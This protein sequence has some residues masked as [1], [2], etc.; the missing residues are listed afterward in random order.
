VLCDGSVCP[1]PTLGAGLI[2]PVQTTVTIVDKDA[3]QTVQFSAPAYTVSETAGSASITV[4]R[5]GT[6]TGI[7]LVN[8][9]PVPGTMRTLTFAAGVRT[10][11]V[12]VP[13]GNN[14]L[15]DG[16]RTITLTL[17]SMRVDGVPTNG[18][19]CGGLAGASCTV[20]LTVLDDD[21]AGTVQFSAT[22]Y[23][24][25]EAMPVA[26]IILQ[27]SGG[28]AS[29]VTVEMVMDPVSSRL[30]APTPNPVTFG[31]GVFM[32]TVTI[33]ILKPNTVDDGDL[34]V[35]LRLVNPQNGLALGPRD[36][37]KLTIVDDDVP[38]VIQFGQ[39]VYT[40]TEPVAP[41][42]VATITLTRTGGAAS[43]VTVDYATVQDTRPCPPFPRLPG[44]SYACAGTNYTATSGT[45]TFAAGQMSQTFPVT[46]LTDGTPTGTM[47][48]GLVLS[49]PGGGATLGAR[50]TATLN[51][52]DID[53][54]VGF[55]AES[56]SVVEGGSAVVTLE[57]TGAV[58]AA[59]TVQYATA[60][61]GPCPAPAGASYGCAGTDYTA[62][63]GTLTFNPGVRTLSFS[64]PTFGNV[65]HEGN[66]TFNVTLTPGVLGATTLVRSSAVVTIVDNDV[67]GAIAFTSSSFTAPSEFG[68]VNLSVRRPSSAAA[69]PVTVA[70]ST[71]DG[72][73]LAGRDYVALSGTLTFPPG[74]SD[75]MITVTILGNSRDDGNRTFQV[76]LSSPTGGAT[77]G[78]QS[79]ANVQINDDDVAGFVQFS[80]VSFSAPTTCTVAP[81]KAALTVKRF[82]GL[83]SG[84]RVDYATV[85]GTGNA[86]LD[87]VPVTDT[88]A[89]GTGESLKTVLIEL[90]PSATRGRTFGVLLSQPRGGAVLG[91]QTTATVT[92]R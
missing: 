56:Y 68:L 25:L 86:L 60:N 75:R 28:A 31:A 82:G 77:L 76:A 26:T 57:R 42:T 90:R 70:F 23:R 55:A 71:V 32:Q 73:A 21:V 22:S 66:R 35:V 19:T 49:D 14:T 20:P 79:T 5:L 40:I 3:D 17:D 38:G 4:Q 18:I 54:A 30:G 53:A 27:R 88:V 52:V 6:P 9:T 12:A 50:T 74:V 64:V 63:A 16:D 11:T 15:V 39:L 1:G 59:A 46:V 81:C 41:A 65:K 45:V 83:A 69:G 36:T 85:D 78:A 10:Q 87:Y 91:S 34:D 84:V 51:I 72:S 62:R 92:L 48:V 13:I 89:F 80:V 29:G 8:F 61:A 43:G 67:A 58:G 44:M 2:P 47:R 24:V 37:A 7:L 33:P